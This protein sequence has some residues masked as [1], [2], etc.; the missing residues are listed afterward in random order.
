MA[1]LQLNRKVGSSGSVIPQGF[2]LY[3]VV[4]FLMIDKDFSGEI[5]I[6]EA[7]DVLKSFSHG[8]DTLRSLIEAALSKGY[9]INSS[10]RKYILIPSH[11]I[12]RGKGS[13]EITLKM[14]MD[15]VGHHPSQNIKVP[16]GLTTTISR[17]IQP[18]VL[19]STTSTRIPKSQKTSHV[20]SKK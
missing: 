12:F 3:N 4:Q 20:E 11:C 5:T 15:I 19:T 18:K 1:F 13:H 6:E 10:V 14:Y 2:V 16:S 9:Q 17:R 7:T 8:K